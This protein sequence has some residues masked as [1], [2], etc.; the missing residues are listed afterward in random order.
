M[1]EAA[2][3]ATIEAAAGRP[4]GHYLRLRGIT[5]PDASW[6]YPQRFLCRLCSAGDLVEQI[7]HDRENWCL[8]HPGQMVWMGPGTTPDTQLVVA[9]SDHQAKAERRFR[10][11]VA[12]GGIDA[13]LHARVWEMVRDNAWLTQPQGWT[14][15]LSRCI[16]DH[17]IRG[18]AALYPETIAVLQVLSDSAIVDRWVGLPS[19]EIRQAI[20]SKFHFDAAPI[21]VLV[22]RI[23][24][25]LRPRR[26]EVRPTR[27]DPLNVPMD[28]VDA[29]EIIDV[30]APYPLWI[31]RRPHAVAEWDWS[32]NDPARDPWGGRGTSYKAWWVCDAGH[33]WESTPYVRAIAGCPYCAG[34]AAWK[35]Q[36][37]LGTQFPALAKEWDRSPGANAGDPDHVGARSNRRVNWNCGQGHRWA[38]TINNR[39]RNGSG[40]PFC[41][42]NRVI[43][44]Q[45]DLAT[46]RPDLMAEW[47]LER[48]GELA[49]GSIGAF[50]I[51][52][53]WWTGSCGHEWDAMVSNRSKGQGC[54]FCAGK[55][56]IVGLTDLASVRPDLAAQW[57]SSNTLRPDAVVPGSGKKVMWVCAESHTW[58]A[59][60]YRRH[61]LGTGCP[62]C[63][64]RY[65]IVGKTDL[66]TVRPDLVREWDA[67]NAREPTEVPA[68]SKQRALWNCKHGHQ[69]EAVIASRT[70]R[71][72]SGCPHCYGHRAVP[73]ET[74][75]ATLRPDLAVEWDISNKSRPER[76]KPASTAMITWRCSSDHVWEARVVSRVNGL[77]CPR[78]DRVV[79]VLDG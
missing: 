66:A 5:Q 54:P 21:D 13:R 26:R 6:I 53:V 41:A 70:G 37:D 16:D 47:N 27:I 3:A 63:F 75:L 78:C 56:P 48:N 79:E 71:Q 51:A 11:L 8:R 12:S 18:R 14:A 49:P 7:P 45:T 15:Q 58:T 2:A 10:R 74:D 32:T 19:D 73:G 60:I 62:F 44:G 34:Q 72:A 38:A 65:A 35:G 23:V 4:E 76:V 67:S 33:T 69:W 40:C 17:E 42:G 36:T 46:L 22:E 55:R 9:H 1:D 64:G 25:W 59:A 39:A 29:P 20:A 24:L 52:K 68:G 43:P 50:S 57:H 77:G 28:V 31:Q 61:V 30:A